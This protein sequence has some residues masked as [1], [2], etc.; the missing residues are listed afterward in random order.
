[1]LAGAA[2]GEVWVDDPDHPRVGLA[3]TSEGHYLA[4]DPQRRDG[5]TGLRQTLPHNAYLICDPGWESVLDRVWDNPFARKHPRQVY[6]YKGQRIPDWQARVPPGYELAAVDRDLLRRTDL[7]QHDEIAGRV[8]EWP[9]LDYFLRRG[10]GWVVLHGSTIASRCIADCAY[11][12]RCEMGVGTLPGHRRQG[13]GSLVVAAAL[14]ECERKGYRQIGWHC[15]ASNRGSIGVALKTGFAKVK[16][17]TAYSAVLPAE[18]ASD[19]SVEEC[20]DWAEHYERA[21]GEVGWYRFYAGGAWALAGDEARALDNLQGLVDGDWQGRPEWL[22]RSFM[23]ESL[24][25]DPRFR[26]LVSRQRQKQAR[27]R[28]S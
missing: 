19:L 27:Q 23:F 12:T 22:E 26:A 25:E 11:D 14:D 10:F 20:R 18:N 5:Y 4:G 28:A 6:R 3:F 13:L 8:E 17:Y 9:S 21:A 1:V 24:Q 16:D 7:E 15:L 2:R